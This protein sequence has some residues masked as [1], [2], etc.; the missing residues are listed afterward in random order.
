M[1]ELM[2]QTRHSNY[3]IYVGDCLSQLNLYVKNVSQTVVITDQ[4]VYDLHYKQLKQY[5]P[6]NTLVFIITPGKNLNLSQ[7]I[8]IFRL[9]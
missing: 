7:R 9:F 2:I 4:T 6:G 1:K 5:L 8:M 3:P